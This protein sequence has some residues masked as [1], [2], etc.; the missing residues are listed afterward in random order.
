[1]SDVD[2]ST[3]NTLIAIANGREK[4][5]LLLFIKVFLILKLTPFFV[6]YFLNTSAFV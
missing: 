5:F 1:M 2:I 3:R 6:Y 4:P